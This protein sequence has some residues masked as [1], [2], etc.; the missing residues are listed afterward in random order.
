MTMSLPIARHPDRGRA[1]AF[2][3]DQPAP[4]TTSVAKNR[5][6]SY[7]L[8]ARQRSSIPFTVA[9]APMAYG[10]TW[11]NSR[12]ARSV[13]R[14]A[15][16]THLHQPGMPELRE[17]ERKRGRGKAEPFGDLPGGQPVRSHADQQPEHVE[18]MLLRQRRQRDHSVCLFHISS[19]MEMMR[20]CQFAS[21]FLDF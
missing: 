18:A 6:D 17:M 5:S 13:Q 8:C 7:R 11:W 19:N 20:L 16:P 15:V 12:N 1:Q 9:S 4:R 10:V 3:R 21:I 14:A 2:G